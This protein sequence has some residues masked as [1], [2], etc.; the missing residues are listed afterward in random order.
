[1]FPLPPAPVIV[2][3]PGLAYL[4]ARMTR[5]RFFVI[6]FAAMA[7]AVLLLTGCSTGFHRQWNSPPA[8]T[9][10]QSAPTHIAGR[11]EGSWLS[12]K[13]GH[14]G[15]LRCVVTPKGDDTYE[16][17]YWAT[18][19]KLFRASYKIDAKVAAANGTWTL[20][21]ERDL[22]RLF[23]GAYRHE[24]EAKDGKLNATYECR[25]DHGTFEMTKVH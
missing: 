8:L 11:W 2:I 18:Y 3:A 10:A 22:G 17:Y 14:H 19:W 25:I 16:F 15:K 12:G 7:A 1:M 20:S 5:F 6:R 9:S 21:G 13:N 4:L 23:G 24:G